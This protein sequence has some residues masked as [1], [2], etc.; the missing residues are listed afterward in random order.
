M[1][2]TAF[3]GNPIQLENNILSLNDEAPNFTFLKQDLSQ[4]SLYDY[5]GKTKVI[6]ALPS[7]D[8]GVCAMETRKFN[9]KLAN[10]TDVIGLVIS[11][12]LPFALKRFCVAEDIKNIDV[13]SDF[14]NNF[15]SQYGLKMVEGPLKGLL[16][17]AVFVVDPNNKIKYVELVS[18][19]TQEPDYEKVLK[20]IS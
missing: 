12:D 3:K 4:S 17:R 11:K 1:S 15:S 8:T 7:V 5:E 20:V 9:A 16:A 14:H 13:A 19:V 18:E 6:I 2:K 10:Q